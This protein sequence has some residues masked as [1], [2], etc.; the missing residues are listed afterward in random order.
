MAHQKG[1]KDKPGMTFRKG[2]RLGK[3]K[4]REKAKKAKEIAGK[5]AETRTLAIANSSRAS[6]SYRS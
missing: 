4:K 2:A 1:N 6:F 3:G 5:K